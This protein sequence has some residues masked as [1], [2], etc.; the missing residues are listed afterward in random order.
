MRGSGAASIA[1]LD[2]GALQ[3]LV[4][5]GACW[6]LAS[7]SQVEPRSLNHLLN[8]VFPDKIGPGFVERFL[9]FRP[10]LD[11]HDHEP[12]EDSAGLIQ[13]AI[14]EGE[15]GLRKIVV[16]ERAD[17][18]FHDDED[19]EADPVYS[20][21]S[22]AFE[23]VLAVAEELRAGE[24][25]KC[26]RCGLVGNLI[27][28]FGLRTMDSKQIRQSWCRVCRSTRQSVGEETETREHT[29]KL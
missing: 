8:R 25:S 18:E 27:G 5:A 6:L 16:V 26:P 23:R 14:L 21:S 12:S 28:W 15:A 4:A 11:S 20:R 13:D 10:P 29:T 3:P 17:L 2:R 7:E 1:G 22:A 24:L 9:N 19:F